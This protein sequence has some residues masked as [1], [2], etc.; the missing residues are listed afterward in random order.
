[1]LQNQVVDLKSNF[2][3]IN[4]YCA[5]RGTGDFDNRSFRNDLRKDRRKVLEQLQVKL[6][7]YSIFDLSLKN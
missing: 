5:K 6:N 4:D 3:E 2:I 1:M 7:K